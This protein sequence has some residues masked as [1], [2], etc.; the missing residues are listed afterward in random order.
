MSKTLI[1]IPFCGFDYSWIDQEIDHQIERD[2][3]YFQEEYGYDDD[4]KDDIRTSFYSQNVDE[5]QEKVCQTYVP[6]WVIPIEEQSGI[7]LDATFESISYQSHPIYRLTR[8]FIEIPTSQVT[9]LMNWIFE[10]MYQELENIVL[11]RFTARDGYYPH[12]SNNLKEWGHYSEWDH[13][14]I[15]TALLI[16][17]DDSDCIGDNY[18]L[19]ESVSETISC[20]LWSTLDDEMQEYLNDLSDK[21]EAEKAQLSLF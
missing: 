19:L 17:F 8:M 20:E 1:E 9:E 5:F 7:E 21:K 14:Q 12:Y 3:D 6:N 2:V 18:Q 4:K 10:N 16:F 15:G 11:D 13:N